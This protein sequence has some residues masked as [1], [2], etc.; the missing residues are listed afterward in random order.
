RKDQTN[1]G[2]INGSFD[3]SDDSSNPFDTSFGFA[4]AALGIYRTFTQSSAYVNGRYRYTNVEWYGQDTWKLNR[5]LTLDYGMRFYWIQPQYD[6]SLQTSNF[7]TS[8]FDPAK[9]PR[10][11]QPAIINGQRSAF[12]PVTGQV[13]LPFAIGRIV[14][15]S[16]NFTNGILPAGKGINKYL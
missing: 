9:A 10:L 6:E 14:P 1:F 5:R 11:Y 13:L 12:D 2:P 7:L 4:N 8:A 3:F 15:G 16:G